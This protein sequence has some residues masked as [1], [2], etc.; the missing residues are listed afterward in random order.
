MTRKT[1]RRTTDRCRWCGR[2]HLK[3]KSE[4]LC[5]VLNEKEIRSRLRP[6]IKSLSLAYEDGKI[7]SV[8]VGTDMEDKLIA[9]QAR[10]AVNALLRFENNGYKP[11]K[12]IQHILDQGFVVNQVSHEKP[13]AVYVL[14][15]GRRKRKKF[16]SLWEA[17]AF[18]SKVVKKYPSAGIV[19]LCRAYD[20]P[21]QYRFTKEKLPRKFKWCPR[22]VTF[23]VYHKIDPPQIFYANVKRWNESKGRYEWTQRKLWVTE[24]QLCGHTNRD[25]VF[26]RANLPW[27]L[28]RIKR[29]RTRVKPRPGTPQRKRR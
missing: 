14:V 5:Y 25:A 24:C 6:K 29:G 12:S 15:E 2:K 28:R 11:P 16:N 10:L 4:S 26:R 7:K 18:H 3:S 23:R 8:F 17:I 13:W 22:C 9:R 27:E 19:S 1:K 20:L 21:P